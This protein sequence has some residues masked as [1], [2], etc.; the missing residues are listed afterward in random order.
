MFLASYEPRKYLWYY[1]VLMLSIS[2]KRTFK[3]INVLDKLILFDSKWVTTS[4]LWRYLGILRNWMARKGIS[5]SF[6][7]KFCSNLL[8]SNLDHNLTVSVVHQ[9]T[10]DEFLEAVIG[11]VLRYFM[12][13]NNGNVVMVRAMDG[14]S[15]A[16]HC[17]SVS[18]ELQWKRIHASSTLFALEADGALDVDEDEVTM[19][20]L[21]DAQNIIRHPELTFPAFI[22]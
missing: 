10:D 4:Q 6:I 7:V 21:V 17:Q 2:N 20:G 1:V 8:H 9:Q 19:N 15:T 22:H 14:V 16:N 13:R 11:R 3:L 12:R 18:Q 5:D